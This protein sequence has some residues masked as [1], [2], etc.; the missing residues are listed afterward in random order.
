MKHLKRSE[1][2]ALETVFKL[3]LI[4][5]CSG[6]KSANLIGTVSSE[7]LENVAVFSSVIHMGT[8]PP[9]LG[10]ITRQVETPK[11]TLAN[12]KN[13]GFYTI[14]HISSDIIKAAH[15]T[16]AKYATKDSEFEKTGL[17]SEYKNEFRAPFVA[18]S[19]VQIAME[20]VEEIHITK[21]NTILV[22]GEIKGIYVKESMLLEDGYL[23]LSKGEIVSVN[24]V[25]G[26]TLPSLI[27][28]LGY[29]KPH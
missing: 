16:S 17:N 23:D 12:I 10:F 24:G 18:E 8:S 19:P 6:Y 27:E 5:S 26:Y 21:N 20:L 3:N 29:A 25:D 28:R 1:I 14:N 22:L 13:S 7:G 9:M 2:D 11:D 15:Q 4:N